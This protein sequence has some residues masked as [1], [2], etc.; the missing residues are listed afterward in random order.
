M[1]V[2]TILNVDT[3][4]C[5]VILKKACFNKNTCCHPVRTLLLS[6]L[7]HLPKGGATKVFKLWFVVQLIITSLLPIRDSRSTF[8]ER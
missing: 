7:G 6:G 1:S 4:N 5:F 3:H 8:S 2:E